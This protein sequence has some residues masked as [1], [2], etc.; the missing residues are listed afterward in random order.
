MVKMS[1]AQITEAISTVEWATADDGDEAMKEARR[2]A[3]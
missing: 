1:Q 2:R 3:R